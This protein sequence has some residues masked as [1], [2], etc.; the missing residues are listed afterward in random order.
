MLMLGLLLSSL[1]FY[2]QILPFYFISDDFDTIIKY[3]SF[4]DFIKIGQYDIHYS[5]VIRLINHLLTQFAWPNPTPFHIFSIFIHLLNIFLVYK[6]AQTFIKNRLK[7]SLAALIF[8]FFFG[9][10]EVVFW[11]AAIN[12]S[13][14][15]TFYLTALIFFIDYL[16]S[17]KTFSFILYQLSFL[18][19]L[20]THEYAISLFPVLFIYWLMNSKLKNI[21]EIFK[22]FLFP[23]VVFLATTILKLIFVKMPLFVRTFSLL[24]SIVFTLRSFVYLFIP[25]PYIV[26]KLSNFVM[27]IVFLMILFLLIKLTNNKKSLFLL[28]WGLMTI[29]L[30]SI[31]S[32][33]Q[34]RYFYISYVPISIY[35]LSVI[36][37]GKVKLLNFLQVFYLIFIF[38]S[39]VSF[40]QNQ[41][42]FWRLN[43]QITKN[44]INTLNKTYESNG[45][46]MTNGSNKANWSNETHESNGVIYFVNLPD[47]ANDSLWK[48]YVFRSGF[49][50]LLN[51]VVH[52]Y[53][54][55]IIFLTSYSPS[56]H[57]INALYVS[58][59]KL[60]SLSKNNQVFVYKEDI[61]TVFLLR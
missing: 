22:L 55:K 41:V 47:S 29:F 54:K 46:N 35:I 58:P 26:D 61:K 23:L 1:L 14:L 12:N 16:S 10:Y 19:A 27:P 44:V 4:F 28:I 5:P 39:G 7:S 13:L 3:K 40:L 18:L 56:K 21:N 34:A 43:S 50:N 20:F 48:A 52:I 9:N 17:K 15:V 57:T 6:I 25:N 59:D 49:V 36:R 53:P 24:K 60:K 32:A 30:Y 45:T 11:F 33:P 31:T 8:A 42:V 51:K 38:I 2:K 37:F